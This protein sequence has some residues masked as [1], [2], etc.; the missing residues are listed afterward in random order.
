MAVI[1]E[2]D[3]KVSFPV[4]A[5]FGGASE[6]VIMKVIT[7]DAGDTNASAW[8]IGEIPGEAKITGCSVLNQAI[9]NG[10]DYDIGI[11]LEDGTVVDVDKIVEAYDMSNAHTAW[12]ELPLAYG[13]ALLDKTVA[14]LAGHVNKVVPAAGETAAKRVY[15]LGLTG[16][17]VG[18]GGV[19]A[20]RIK[21]RDSI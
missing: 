18:D 1:A 13:A 8:L 2:M 9:A 6:K 5:L 10:T 17:V 15:R 11:F 16:N 3:D 4:D 19:I 14:E 12:T 7:S 20:I 21:Y